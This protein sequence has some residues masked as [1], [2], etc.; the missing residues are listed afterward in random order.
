MSTPFLSLPFAHTYPKESMYSSASHMMCSLAAPLGTITSFRIHVLVP[1][2][3]MWCTK[4]PSSET[5]ADR[6]LVHGQKGGTTQ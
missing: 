4:C 5:T 1:W 2:S 3:I 6:R